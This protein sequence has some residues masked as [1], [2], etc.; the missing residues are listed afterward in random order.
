MPFD[1]RGYLELARFLQAQAGSAAN[2]EAFLRSALS[3]AYYAAFCHARNH[4]R[5]HLGLRL[6]GE[7]D[8]HGAL[9]ARFKT[10]KMKGISDKLQRLREWRNACDYH[11]LLTFDLQSNVISG[12]SMANAV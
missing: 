6:R 1:W 3:R 12:L 10:G 9:R 4:A 7:A 8:D 2:H 11:D 5:D